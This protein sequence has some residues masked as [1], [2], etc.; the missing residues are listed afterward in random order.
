[1]KQPETIQAMR[2]KKRAAKDGGMDG[3]T[4]LTGTGGVAPSDLNVS[5][6]TLLGQ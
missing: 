5:K 3:G 6:P 1:V 4:M 2:E